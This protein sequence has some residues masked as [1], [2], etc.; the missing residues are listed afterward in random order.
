MIK[1]QGVIL[2]Q[3]HVLK[4][5]LYAANNRFKTMKNVHYLKGKV[6]NISSFIKDNYLLDLNIGY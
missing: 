2:S 1:F 5:Y 4:C 3:I 6:T